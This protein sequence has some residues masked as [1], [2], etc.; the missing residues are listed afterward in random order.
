MWNKLTPLTSKQ[1]HR[2]RPEWSVVLK[3][4]QNPETE[5]THTSYPPFVK[6]CGEMFTKCLIS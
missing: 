4:R 2:L 1:I 6:E 5:R 3:A